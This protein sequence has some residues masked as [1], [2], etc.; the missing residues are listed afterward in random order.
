MKTTHAHAFQTLCRAGACGLPFSHE[1]RHPVQGPLARDLCPARAAASL[2]AGLRQGRISRPACLPQSNYIGVDITDKVLIL[3]KRNIERIY[4]EQGLPIDNV[5]TLAHDIERIPT[6]LDKADRVERIY[7]NFC[8]PWNK[9]ANHKKHRL[10]HTRQLLLYRPFLAD[11]AEIWFKCDDDDL[12][13][14]TLRYMAEAGFEV[15]WQ[16]RDLHADEPSWN[17]RTEHEQMFTEMGIPTKALIA[18]KTSLPENAPAPCIPHDI[19][20]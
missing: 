18:R 2:G 1:R 4:A 16:T 7:I 12:F 8:N 11:G 14:D 15:T 9:K 5:K 10:T 6:L 20:E 13:K 19:M 3:A 17:I